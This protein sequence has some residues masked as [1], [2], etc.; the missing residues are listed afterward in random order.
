MPEFIFINFVSLEL[1]DTEIFKSLEI[2]IMASLLA[3]TSIGTLFD[4]YPGFSRFLL[5]EIP[6]LCGV[7]IPPRLDP[8]YLPVFP[9]HSSRTREDMWGSNLDTFSEIS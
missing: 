4:L 2:N 5:G 1:S 7:T 9:K 6:L 8:F 3:F